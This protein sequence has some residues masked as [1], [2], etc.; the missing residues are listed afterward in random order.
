V[1]KWAWDN[2]PED[3]KGEGKFFRKASPGGWQE[4]LTPE[5]AKMV[6]QITG[7][8]LKDFYPVNG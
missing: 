5:Q 8:L 3:R 4:D 7:P 1:E 6:E 2:I